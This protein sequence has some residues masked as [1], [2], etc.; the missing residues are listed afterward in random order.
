MNLESKLTALKHRNSDLPLAERAELSCRLAKQFERT[1]EYEAACEALGEFWPKRDEPPKLDGLDELTTAEVLLR[2]AALAGCLGSADQTEGSQEAAKNLIT[3]S[4]EIFEKL[5]QPARAAEARGDLALCYWREGSYDEARVQ[6]RSALHLLPEGNDELRAILLIRAG[7]IE[8]R[9]QRLHEALRFY[10]EAAPL[11]ER[12]E[13]HSLKGAF[14]NEFGLVFRRLATPENREDY[15][16]RALIE[17][18]AA[19][20]HFEQ[21]ENHRYLA[22]V[23]NN[24]G[25]LYF[26]IGQYKDAHRHL[27][28]ARH[29]FLELKDIGTAAQVDETRARTLLAEGHVTEAERMVRSAVKTL[30]RGGEQAVLAEAL[31][32]YGVVLARLGNYPRSRVLLERAIEVAE[33]TGDLE[34]AGRAKLSIIEELGKKMPA[35]ELVSVYRS[36]IDLLKG[37]QDPSTG[38]RLISCAERLLEVFGPSEDEGGEPLEHTWESFSFTQYVREAERLVIQRAL[39]DAGGSVTKAARL[40]GMSHQSLIYL[41]NSRHNEL[42]KTRS[43]VRKRRRHIFSQ[44]RKIKSKVAV[45]A[46]PAVDRL[47]VLHVEDN[48]QVARLIVDALAPKGIDVDSCVSGTTALKILTSDARYDVIIVDNDLPGLGGL[49]LVRR[50]RNMARWRSTPIIMLSGDDCEKEAWRAGVAAFLRKPEAV[51]QVASTI[52]RLL[53]ERKEQ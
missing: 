25:N 37:S 17:Y 12:S 1:G 51:D 23:E 53:E 13:D 36:A 7:I 15:L 49:E 22:R 32:T 18:A 52:T 39:V 19:S 43:T 48:K 50:A 29:L 14:H 3:H 27:D 45:E 41:I 33:T 26:T 2:V 40:L 20:F 42:L 44:P 38:K 4:I 34:G 10:N 28:R 31:T 6:L 35:K 24:L 46:S 11:I 5:G 30:E 9:T 21:A 8:E 16:D 47:S